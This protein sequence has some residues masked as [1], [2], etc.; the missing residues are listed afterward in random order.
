MIKTKIHHLLKILFGENITALLHGIKFIIDYQTKAN[1]DLEMHL[2]KRLNIEGS[3]A[4]DV[5]ANGSNWSFWLSEL[6]G[7]KGKV[8]AFEPH[9]YYFKATKFSILL[10]FRR[11]I[12]LL[13]SALG[14]E[15]SII[16]LVIKENN[17]LLTYRSRI[18]GANENKKN[19]ETSNVEINTLDNFLLNKKINN[20][21][22]IK[23]DVEGHE[24]NVL[25]GAINTIKKHLPIL[26]FELNLN[27]D[28]I[29]KYTEI[30]K[31][32]NSFNYECYFLN[33]N[34]KLELIDDLSKIYKMG[35]NNI[36][37]FNSKFD[38][39]SFS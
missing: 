35:N 26:I 12:T 38:R 39:S 4:I 18:L 11:N 10:S 17:K 34:L 5:G 37:A 19:I 30:Y 32:I 13:K 29:T 22:I 7:R 14:S 24:F 31:L 20:I 1:L 28:V 15:K 27:E 21:S 23:I 36:V 3:I 9:P 6:V 8:I 16:K 2:L 33:N 25:K